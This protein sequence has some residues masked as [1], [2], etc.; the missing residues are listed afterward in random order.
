V[1]VCRSCNS[2]KGKKH[3]EEFRR[4]LA[5]LQKGPL[6][7]FQRMKLLRAAGVADPH[8]ATGFKFYFEIVGIYEV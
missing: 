8:P 7:D 5:K 2:R 3:P 6:W 1:P 4:V